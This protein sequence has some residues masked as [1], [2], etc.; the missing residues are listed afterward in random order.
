MQQ[1]LSRWAGRDASK[2]AQPGL[3]SAGRDQYLRDAARRVLAQWYG[4]S[5]QTPTIGAAKQSEEETMRVNEIMCPDVCI[6]G[7]DETIREA[8]KMM[9]DVDAGVLPVSDGDRLVGMITDRDIAVRAVGAGKGPDTR[10]RD[11]MS[12]EVLYCFEDEEVEHVVENMGEVQ[13]RRLPVMNRQKRL[14]G[15]VSLGD[16]ATVHSS[17]AAG[18]AL[19]GIAQPGGKHTQSDGRMSLRW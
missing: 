13:V 4:F 11:V 1:I 12:K 17:E 14:V 3:R 9:G 2:Q 18:L 5:A 19:S 16:V 15:I 10:I 8:A 7:A 6:I